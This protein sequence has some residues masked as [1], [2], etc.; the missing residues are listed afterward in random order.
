M[1]HRPQLVSCRLNNALHSKGGEIVPP[2]LIRKDATRLSYPSA[3]K[4]EG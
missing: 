2:V 1:A 4:V 3:V